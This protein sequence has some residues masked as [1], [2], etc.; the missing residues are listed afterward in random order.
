MQTM[1]RSKQHYAAPAK[2]FKALGQ[3]SRLLIVDALRDGE[4]T[5]TEL[6][7]LVGDDISTVSRHL[8]V[9]R[10]AGVVRSRRAGVTLHY[11]LLM[12]CALDFLDCVDNTIRRGELE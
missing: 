8:A 2:V 11:S 7:E 3:E 12:T 6:A 1:I 4:R 9:L 5:V 10:E